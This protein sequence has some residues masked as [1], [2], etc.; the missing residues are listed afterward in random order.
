MINDISI[1]TLWATSLLDSYLFKGIIT[2]NMCCIA[3]TH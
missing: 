3:I 1:M 2:F